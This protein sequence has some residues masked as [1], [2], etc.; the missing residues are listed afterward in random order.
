M[1]HP[2]RSDRGMALLLSLF[3]VFIATSVG[4]SMLMLSDSETAVNSN[5]RSEQTAYYASKAGLEEARDRM[6]SG[7]GTGITISASLPTVAP[8]AAGGVLYVLNPTGSETVAPWDTANAYFDD[9]ICKEINCGAALTPPTSGWYVS[10][11]PTASSTYA[12][13]PV[14]PYKWMRITLKTNQSAAGSANTMYVDGNSTYG[15]YYVCWNG[16]NEV[17]SST[18]CTSPQSPVYMLTALAMTRDGSRRMLQ[19]EVTQPEIGLTFPGALTL[20]GT[21]DVMSAPTSSN[22]QIQGTDHAACGGSA[23]TGSYPAVAVND[24]SDQ[25]TVIGAIPSNRRTNYSGSGSSSPDVE[26]ASIPSN[27]QSVSSLQTLV[28]TV[29]AS[30]N[31]VYTGSVTSLSNTGTASAPQIIAV[32][33]DLTLSGSSTG[34][35][36]LL[37][38]GTFTASGSVGWNGVVLVVGKGIFNYNGGGSGANSYNGAVIVAQTVN[39]TT[40]AL[41]ATPGAPTFTWGGGGGNGIYYASACINKGIGLIAYNVIATH[42]LLD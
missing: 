15:S 10:P 4:L 42:E 27:L 8:G 3:A 36:I 22:F 12:T 29:E 39:P 41:L 28:S 7:A 16:T 25:A 40:G 38:T 20:D 5:Y 33:G 9:E 32:E 2:Q 6:R 26:A 24:P 21:G 23:G 31:Q 13:N 11:A 37:V 1:T 19:Y 14:L 34:Y 30:A 18:A 17:T 35:G